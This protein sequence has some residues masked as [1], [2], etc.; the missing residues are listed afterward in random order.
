MGACSWSREESG[1][2]RN[3]HDPRRCR[4]A[5]M[6]VF[7]CLAIAWPTRAP[8]AEFTLAGKTVNLY[9]GGG[10]G[11]GVDNYARTLAP[12]FAKHLPGHPSITVVNMGASGGVQGM[13]Y[14]YNVAAKDGTAFGMTNSGAVAEPVMGTTKVN[15]EID[16]YRWLGSLTRGDTVCGVW[17][18]STI[19]ILADAR[20]RE[21]PL[22]ATGA[23]SGPARAA[24]MLNALLQ[25]QFKP[26]SGYPGNAMF[27]AVERREVEG[28]CNTL[29]SFRT[30]HPHW[31][32]ERKF[33]LLVQV[34]LTADPE[35][36]DL[37]RA[38]DF[39]SRDEDRQ[40]LDLYLLPYEFNNP[41]MLP[42]GAADDAYRAYRKAFDAT[43][44]DT[45]YLA[46]VAARLQRIAPRDGDDVA[47]LAKKLVAAP[48]EIVQRMIEITSPGLTTQSPKN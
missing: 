46:D 15:Y 22:S 29:S 16:K 35:Y 7:A 34:A 6:T 37:P 4:L 25:T 43:M 42:P 9:V 27:L 20:K 33:R 45:A 30:S 5:A 32:R 8:A 19:Q 47:A 48:R 10:I 21:V 14:L 2:I 23:T 11:G 31:L 40:I 36:P 38:V 41:L 18:E 17:H 24:R 44:R 13:Q 39:I 1:M 26:I 12:H 3:I 28:T